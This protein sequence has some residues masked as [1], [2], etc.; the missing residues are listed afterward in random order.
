MTVKQHYENL[1]GNLYSWMTGDF[2]SKQLEHQHIF[3]NLGIEKPRSTAR[4]IDLGSGHGIQ[5]VALAHLGFNVFALD[6]N[7]HLLDELT[8]NARGLKIETAYGDL[9]DF[10]HHIKENP[11]LIVCMGDTLT[12]LDSPAT[13]KKLFKLIYN[14]LTDGGRIALSFRDLTRELKAGQRFIPVKSDDTRILTCFL[15]YFPEY[16]M[17]HDIVNE[18]IEG[19]WRQKTSAYPKLRIS[20][21]TVGKLLS[22]EGFTITHRSEINRMQFLVG[23][24]FIR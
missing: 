23:E 22:D 5:S 20:A 18:K 14:S 21:D 13:I 9:F 16:V 7:R 1:L 2:S 6:F 10:P 15:E 19:E 4:A 3:V 24:K 11:E 17:V 8:V 12:H